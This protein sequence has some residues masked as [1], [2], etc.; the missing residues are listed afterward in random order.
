MEYASG[1]DLR[2]HLPGLTECKIR[3][4]F[5]MPVLQ[6]LNVLH[7]KVN[8]ARWMLVRGWEGGWEGQRVQ[9][10]REKAGCRRGAT[11]VEPVGLRTSVSGR[12]VMRRMKP[13][14]LP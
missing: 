14:G 13:C 2:K 9:T 4:F 11:Q 8:W 3:D 7:N 1:G 10:N 5:I 12:C 6:A